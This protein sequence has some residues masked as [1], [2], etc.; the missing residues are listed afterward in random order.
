MQNVSYALVYPNLVVEEVIS[1]VGPNGLPQP[2]GYVV[3]IPTYFLLNPNY[4]MWV[5]IV[6][7][8]SVTPGWYLTAN[9]YVYGP[10]SVVLTAAAAASASSA[11]TSAGASAASATAAAGSATASAGSATASAGSATASAG[12]ATAAAASLATTLS[13]AAS[14]PFPVFDTAPHAI[15]NGVKNYTGLVGGSGGTNG[16]FALTVSGGGGSGFVGRFVVAGGA[17]TAIYIDNPGNSFTSAPTF[18]FS[19]SSGLTGASATAVIGANVPV[20]GYFY[21]PVPSTDTMTN[22]Y[23]VTTGPAYNLLGQ[24]PSSSAVFSPTY[25]ST[26]MARG[27]TQDIANPY[28]RAPLA[29][30]PAGSSDKYWDDI[31]SWTQTGTVAVNADGTITLAAGATISRGI[32]SSDNVFGTNWV[33][34]WINEVTPTAGVF[35]LTFVGKYVGT[36]TASTFTSQSLG[37]GQYKFAFRNNNGSGVAYFGV[38]CT[39]TNSGG[40]PVTIYPLM[41]T[42]VNSAVMPKLRRFDNVV[43]VKALSKPIRDFYFWKSVGFSSDRAVRMQTYRKLDY[44]LDTVNGSNSNSGTSI[45]APKQTVASLLPS[46]ILVDQMVGI[47]RNSICR[48]FWGSYYNPLLGGGNFGFVEYPP[49][50]DTQGR[51]PIITGSTPVP[52]GSWT[53]NGD[54]TYTF[55]WTSS[56]LMQHTGYSYVYPLEI[57]TATEAATPYASTNVMIAVNTYANCV[58]TAGSYYHILDGSP[59]TTHSITIHPSDGLAPGSGAYRYEVPYSQSNFNA[60]A[61]QYPGLL[62][63]GLEI[64]N[65]GSGYGNMSGA[66][67]TIFDRCITAY[68]GQHANVTR[69]AYVQRCLFY[70]NQQYIDIYSSNCGGL[71]LYKISLGAPYDSEIM[72]NTVRYNWFWGG[73]GFTS[74]TG[75][76]VDYHETDISNCWFIGGR[77]TKNYAGGGVVTG[78]AA[79]NI[80]QL[81]TST[82]TTGNTTYSYISDCFFYQI[83]GPFGTYWTSLKDCLFQDCAFISAV[84]I[85]SNSV[86]NLGNNYQIAS[87]SNGMGV[88]TAITN[89]LVHFKYN[90][91]GAPIANDTTI[92]FPN[93]YSLTNASNHN[94]FLIEMDSGTNWSPGQKFTSPAPGLQDY[95][96]YI[97]VSGKEVQTGYSGGGNQY[98]WEAYQTTNIYQD[99]N[100][101]YIDLRSDPRGAKAVFIDPANGDYR[102]A[103][104]DVAQQCANYCLANGVGPNWTIAGWPIIPTV[105]Q[106]AQIIR[107]A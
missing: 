75:G 2:Y 44:Y 58:A 77:Y 100:S 65:S 104:T 37:S 81:P 50:G 71:T 32:S 11:A 14:A 13:I 52:N 5:P 40:S 82:N 38:T 89:C 98:G 69:S 105:D 93:T 57:A 22:F 7:N 47:A 48:E 54:G 66:T 16:T 92:G 83:A 15:S 79:L 95:N 91:F 27:N 85:I 80:H 1:V 28:V 43:P 51:M 84:P 70:H 90:S 45:R 102:F 46:G 87:L 26:A 9:G 33:Y 97:Q 8:P 76:S 99:Q 36:P 68:G 101:I 103:D 29:S 88:S 78:G 42:L 72:S 12:S 59:T 67:N 25:V 39:I 61:T 64:V 107:E 62:C 34:L 30:L 31:S 106:I 73:G 56:Q 63:A 18:S 4:P 60:N 19:A 41:A 94:I 6:N 24:I 86:I 53:N 17:V 55:S 74:H 49:S 3:D 35:N 10:D 96:I 21:T 23:S 20:G